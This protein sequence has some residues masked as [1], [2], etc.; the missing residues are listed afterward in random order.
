MKAT[1]AMT[2]RR[3]LTIVAGVL[4]GMAFCGLALAFAD[5]QFDDGP[6]PFNF[7]DLLLAASVC[8][9][10]LSHVLVVATLIQRPS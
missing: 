1:P 7:G 5:G 8:F 4:L 3:T 10:V 2:L 6:A 9:V